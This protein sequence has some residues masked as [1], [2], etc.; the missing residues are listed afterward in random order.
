MLTVSE[1]REKYPPEEL[2][3]HLL[4]RPVASLRD[5]QYLYGTLYTL[6]TASSGEYARYLTLETTKVNISSE[7]EN[8]VATQIDL[9]GETPRLDADTP[10]Y[11]TTFTDKL[12]ERIA[13]CYYAEKGSGLDHSITQQSKAGG[14]APDRLGRELWKRP[15]ERWTR[16]V[17]VRETAANHEEGWM[18]TALEAFANVE[19]TEQRIAQVVIDRIGWTRTALLTVRI[20]TEKGEPYRWPGEFDVFNAC[21]KAQLIDKL[22][23]KG[24]DR[25]HSSGR[26]MDFVTETEGTAVGTISDPMNYYLTKQR[27]KFPGINTAEAWRTHPLTVD[28]AITIRNA[29]SFLEACTYRAYQATV[30]VLPYFN[31]T[32]TADQAYSLYQWLTEATALAT[33]DDR[34]YDPVELGYSS[35]LNTFGG[36]SPLRFFVGA[37]HNIQAS[38]CEHIRVP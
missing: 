3:E 9:S 20:R 5:I 31:R 28:T 1:F 36:E 30:F 35:A 4:D 16:E 26:A 18:V 13:H 27:E 19:E 32:V 12:A 24:I 23:S 6:G 17:A 22:G 10:V 21:M 2:Q 29:S 7:G 33:S 8:V 37:V 11:A 34:S 14:Y 38:L 15:L 25:G